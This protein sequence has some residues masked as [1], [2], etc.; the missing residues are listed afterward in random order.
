MNLQAAYSNRAN[1]IPVFK[2]SAKRSKD[3]FERLI[4]SSAMLCQFI[5]LW[6]GTRHYSDVQ[7]SMQ[8]W[9]ISFQHCRRKM[10]TCRLCHFHNKARE[11]KSSILFPFS[12]YISATRKLHRTYPGAETSTVLKVAWFQPG[13]AYLLLCIKFILIITKW[14]NGKKMARCIR[15]RCNSSGRAEK[16]W[17]FGPC[18]EDAHWQSRS[19][20]LTVAIQK[21]Q[22][23]NAFKQRSGHVKFE[24]CWKHRKIIQRKHHQRRERNG[25]ASY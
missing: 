20:S 7:D 5:W 25:I 22:V 13:A 18:A 23:G 8:G 15:S 16:L 1:S 10:Y 21:V 24:L 4:I 3:H 12:L 14:K 17:T 19:P 6:R 11:G 2:S 9:C